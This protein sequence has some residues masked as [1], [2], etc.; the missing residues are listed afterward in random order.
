MN[1]ISHA[2]HNHDI[3]NVL[4]TTLV[5]YSMQSTHYIK[6]VFSMLM[7]NDKYKLSHLI[8]NHS[9]INFKFHLSTLVFSD[10]NHQ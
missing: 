4:H 3:P 10:G 8:W 1:D 6:F 9:Q 7:L 5:H 2:L